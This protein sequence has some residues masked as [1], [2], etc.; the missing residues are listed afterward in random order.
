MVFGGREH[1]HHDLFALVAGGFCK[2]RP[3]AGLSVQVEEPAQSAARGFGGAPWPLA[4]QGSLIGLFEFWRAVFGPDANSRA[5]TDAD[6]PN[7]VAV[8][9]GFP[10]EVRRA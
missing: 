8:A 9:V 1:P 4:L 6:I 5:F 3:G 2:V 7:H 10:M